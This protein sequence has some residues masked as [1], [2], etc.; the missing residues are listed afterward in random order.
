MYTRLSQP[1]FCCPEAPG[2]VQ[3]IYF[4]EVPSECIQGYPSLLF[5]ALRRL[6]LASPPSYIFEV[7]SQCIHGYPSLLFVALRRL[8]L[9]SPC[10]YIFEVPSPCIQRYPTFSLL[11]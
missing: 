7:P 10:T 11:P 2:A 9:S 3:P 1:S 4:F 8:R 6:G 5:V